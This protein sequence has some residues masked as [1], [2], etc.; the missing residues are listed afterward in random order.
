MAVK[1]PNGTTVA[2]AST[3]G[4]AKTISAITNA[5]EAVATLPASHG[6][7]TGDIVEVTSGW[8]KLSGRI[9]RVKSVSTNDVTLEGCD[10]S[11]TVNFPVGSGIGSLRVCSV[12]T[13]ITQVTNVETSGGEQQFTTYAF[14]EDDTERK[15]P[16][17]KSAQDYTV[18]MA[19]DPSL[20]WY[21]LLSTADADRAPRCI[22][23]TIP[24]GSIILFSAYVT[25]NKT[26]TLTLNQ[27][28]TIKSSMAL[29]AAQ[30]RY[31]S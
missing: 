19:D 13:Q 20:P 27:I 15:I 14:L 9:F 26:P 7:V 8:S 11:S 23:M 24:S 4:T 28:M 5:T 16:T 10:T 6:V 31:A 2:V 29:V 21:T 18:T 22:K 25:L 3:Y 12:F 17:I 1:L 30:T